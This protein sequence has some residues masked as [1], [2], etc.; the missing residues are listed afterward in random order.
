MSSLIQILLTNFAHKSREIVSIVS[1]IDDIAEQTNLLAL[2]T[3]IEVAR[4][5]EHGR[6]FA[7]VADE[8]RALAEKTQTSISNIS[9]VIRT[10]Q[11]EIDG[12]TSNSATIYKLAETSHQK[13]DKF[14]H[15]F[16]NMGVNTSE[17]FT[18][19]SQLQKRLL[20]S[21]AKLDHIVYKSNLYLSFNIGKQ[22]INFSSTTPISPI[23]ED[24]KNDK[25]IN[26]LIPRHRLEKTKAELN[27]YTDNA[28][29]VL[30][31]TITKENSKT[32]VENLQSL[33]VNSKI[34][35][36]SLNITYDDRQKEACGSD[37]CKI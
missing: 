19:F 11:D 17:L 29:A 26:E 8:V 14:N 16:D 22:N 32:I 5:G 33:E 2:N 6:G 13:I 9:L 23:L 24:N 28:L 20:I 12:I 30:G 4:A 35:M 15:I 34:L 36:D 21:I 31:Q 18:V 7:V 1:I 27:T 3:A 10:I 25:F 37:G